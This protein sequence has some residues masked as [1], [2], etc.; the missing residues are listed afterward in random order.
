MIQY[1][2]LIKST[3]YPALGCTI[4]NRN[5]NCNIFFT[6]ILGNVKRF[7]FQPQTDHHPECISGV[8]RA[9]RQPNVQD[10]RVANGRVNIFLFLNF[11]RLSLRHMPSCIFKLSVWNSSRSRQFARRNA[12]QLFLH[13]CLSG[14][15]SSYRLI[16]RVEAR[17]TP[18]MGSEK[19][20]LRKLYL[21]VWKGKINL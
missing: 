20:W 19:Y 14:F 3:S 4:A 15:S 18:T 8:G 13:Y 7:F 17:Y 6:G 2:T 1:S 11:I 16:L 5:F 21:F 9:E 10:E 12:G